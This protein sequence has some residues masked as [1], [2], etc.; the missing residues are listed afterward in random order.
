MSGKSSWKWW[1]AVCLGATLALLASLT[2]SIRSRNESSRLIFMPLGDVAGGFRSEHWRLVW[3]EYA[4]WENAEYPQWSIPWWPVIAVETGLAGIALYAGW[5]SKRLP[6]DRNLIGAA[7]PNERGFAMFIILA[8]VFVLF[9]AFG[10]Q[11]VRLPL[12]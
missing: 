3:I 8:C 11:C 7:S 1:M 12:L 6:V 2:W 10:V 4:G 5:R 9:I